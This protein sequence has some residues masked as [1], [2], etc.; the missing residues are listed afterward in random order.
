MPAASSR[1]TAVIDEERYW[2]REGE[3]RLATFD[4][5]K[6]ISHADAWK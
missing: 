3:K 1:I 4:P 2:A 5:E 6:A